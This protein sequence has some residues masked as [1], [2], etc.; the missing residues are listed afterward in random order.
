MDITERIN[1]GDKRSLPKI[2]KLVSGSDN[3]TLNKIYKLYKSIIKTKVHKV[4]NIKTAEALKI[5]E[6]TQRDLNIALINEFSLICKK[7]KINTNQ[8]LKYRHK[9]EF[10]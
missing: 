10:C 6:N 5:I 4:P 8:V 2:E 3:E 1:V 9:M 7:L